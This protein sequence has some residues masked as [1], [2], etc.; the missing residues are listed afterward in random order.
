MSIKTKLAALGIYDPK[1]LVLRFSDKISR[2]ENNWDKPLHYKGKH[3]KPMKRH[4]RKPIF[5][6]GLPGTGTQSNH[7]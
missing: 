3:G 2:P 4:L 5:V 7:E 6:P 1:A